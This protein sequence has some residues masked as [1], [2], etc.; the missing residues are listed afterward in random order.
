MLGSS[1]KNKPA[2]SPWA[3]DPSHATTWSR[4]SSPSPFPS[5]SISSTTSFFQPFDHFYNLLIPPPTSFLSSPSFFFSFK[6]F[7]TR[8][9]FTTNSSS[10]GCDRAQHCKKDRKQSFIYIYIYSIYIYICLR[11]RCRCLFLNWLDLTVFVF[12]LPKSR[13]MNQCVHADCI[14]CWFVQC[15]EG[16]FTEAKPV[17]SHV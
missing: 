2:A 1:Y 5:S 12:W 14:L 4:P 16:W 6:S 8:S 13:W 3:R 11:L 17:T 9:T 10:G 15:H 7:F